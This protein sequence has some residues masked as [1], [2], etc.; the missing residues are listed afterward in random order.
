MQN[1]AYPNSLLALV[2][3]DVPL[4]PDLGRGEHATGSAHVTEGSLTGTVST[5]T[6]DT[7]DTGDSATYSN[8]RQHS[9]Y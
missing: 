3:L 7:G 1:M 4:A 5:T 2:D 8:K 9:S 6:G